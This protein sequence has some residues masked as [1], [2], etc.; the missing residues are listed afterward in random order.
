MNSTPG[1]LPMFIRAADERVASLRT[2]RFGTGLIVLAWDSPTP[3]CARRLRVTVDGRPVTLPIVESRIPLTDGRTRHLLV[4]AADQT[5]D[6]PATIRVADG[7]DRPIASTGEMLL[8]G[9]E[10]IEFGTRALIEGVGPAGRARLLRFLLDVVP[11]TFR[12]GA[13]P[14]FAA[15]CRTL[16]ADLAPPAQALAWRCRASERRLL[17]ECLVPAAFEGPVLGI[18]VAGGGVARLALP[19]VIASAT[20]DDAPRRLAVLIEAREDDPAPMLVLFGGGAFV[21]CKPKKPARPLPDAHDWLAAGRGVSRA[22][23]WALLDGLARLSADD[24]CAEARLRELRALA[25]PA[26]VARA[27]DP[28]LVEASVELFLATPAGVFVKGRITDPHGFAT[29]LLLERAADRRPVVAGEFVR[30]PAERVGAQIFLAWVPSDEPGAAEGPACL[31]LRLRSGRIVDLGEGPIPAPAGRVRDLILTAVPE[32]LLS[33]TVV[34]RC[35]APAVRAVHEAGL[36]TAP[37]PTV[38]AYGAPPRAPKVSIVVPLEDDPEILRTRTA[39]FA[40][41]PGL[42][43]YDIVYAARRSPRSEALEGF[44]AGLQA[45][46]GPS[47][48]LLV[49]PEDAT[50]PALVNAAVRIARAPQLVLLAEGAVPEAPDWS[51]RLLDEQRRLGS[52]AAV[53][54]ARLV[55]EDGSLAAPLSPRLAGLAGDDPCRSRPGFPAG[56]PAAAEARP[57]PFLTAGCIAT[58]RRWFERLGGLD[59]G[60]LTLA[61]A[62]ADFGLKTWQAGRRVISLPSPV[63]VD[64][65][66]GGDGR[67][68]GDAEPAAAA[69]DRAALERRW[70]PLLRSLNRRISIADAVAPKPRRRAPGNERTT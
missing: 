24:P 25:A 8:P 46:Y 60:H 49:L 27:G 20:A 62:L 23:R 67:D 17:G 19:P 22:A 15:A 6:A 53:I 30:L 57:I 31:K 34:D 26:P 64:L 44:V 55:H 14:A 70:R 7:G 33:E 47:F 52:R 16:L 5:T 50:Q 58:A 29:D 11:N 43:G 32:A 37:V 54:G 40:L 38:T 45:T 1:G 36:A 10:P 59:E 68:L 13:E 41:D 4:A 3:S 28:R 51:A 69:I 39:L 12:A 48:R 18:V 66:A 65:S 21:C 9:D 35:L 2:H 63:F 56:W 61:A 42:R